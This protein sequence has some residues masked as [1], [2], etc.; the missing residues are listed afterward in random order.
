MNTIKINRVFTLCLFFVLVL[1]RGAYGQSFGLGFYGYEVHQEKRTGLDLSPGKTLCFSDNFDLSFD[2]AFRPDQKT[3]FGY[4]VRI[5]EDNRTNIDI[6]HNDLSK[7]HKH[8]KLVIGDTYS[9]LAF[10]IPKDKLFT[11]WNN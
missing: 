5:I 1:F 8:F 7:D 9:K 4:I 11:Q 10:E 6:I 2:V 3:Y